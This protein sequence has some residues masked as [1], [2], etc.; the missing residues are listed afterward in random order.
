MRLRSFVFLVSGFCFNSTH[1]A[2][3]LVTTSSFTNDHALT[4]SIAALFPVVA[5]HGI[6]TTSWSAALSK[7]ISHRNVT[8]TRGID[9]DL[10]SGTG[11]TLLPGAIKC[12][13]GSCVIA[14]DSSTHTILSQIDADALL[15]NQFGT[16]AGT[17][18]GFSLSTGSSTALHE[19]T[20]SMIYRTRCFSGSPSRE[21]TLVQDIEAAVVAKVE[22]T[23]KTFNQYFDAVVSAGGTT[24]SELLG[25]YD[26]IARF[27][28]R[29]GTHSATQDQTLNIAASS[30][31]ATVV[32]DPS[33]S[34]DL[35]GTI[36]SGKIS[37]DGIQVA[38]FNS[39]Q[40][41]QISVPLGT[42]TVS[43]SVYNN[44]G[45]LSQPAEG[46]IVV[47]VGP[48]PPIAFALTSL[49]CTP[50]PTDTNTAV[51]CTVMGS[52]LDS[53]N[54]QLAL[55]GVGCDIV[56][57]CAIP[58]S[59]MTKKTATSISFGFIPTVATS[60]TLKGTVRSSDPWL[61]AN[62]T[63]SVNMPSPAI[64]RLDSVQTSPSSP[65]VG[66]VRITANGAGITLSTTMELTGPQC[67]PCVANSKVSQTSSMLVEDVQISNPGIYTIK[68]RDSGQLTVG[69]DIFFAASPT[70]TLV[71][72][73][74]GYNSSI[75]C[76]LDGKSLTAPVTLN[77]QPIGNHT[78]GCNAPTGYTISGIT[79]AAAQTLA[80]NSTVTWT[81]AVKSSTQPL[82]NATCSVS[83]TS[84][85]AGQRVTYTAGWSGGGSPGF[86]WTE[87]ISGTVNPIQ[88]TFNSPGTYHASV[89]IMNNGQQ[90]TGTCPAVIV[91]AAPDFTFTTLASSKSVQA[92]S[93]VGFDCGLSP[94][95]NFTGQVTVF[96]SGLPSNAT[97]LNSS[98]VFNISPTSGAS[99]TLLLQTTGGTPAGIYPIT[100]TAQGSGINHVVNL[101]L[102]VTAPPLAPLSLSAV[103][104][105]PTINLGGGSSLVCNA[106][107]GSGGY[108]YSLNNGSYQA[109]NSTVVLPQD[110]G[111][112]VYRCS[113]RDNSGSTAAASATL[114]VNGVAPVVS[115]ATWDST[116]THGIPF[117]GWISGSGFTPSSV[118]KFFGPGCPSSGCQQPPAGVSVPSLTSIRLVNVNL[119]AG[120]WQYQVQTAYGTATG[121]LT[122]K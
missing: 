77:N 57:G 37:V 115:G 61:A 79:P 106:S 64:V 59:S 56:K 12:V 41:T 89:T 53:P 18:G 50:N 67:S 22:G 4:N 46:V 31:P 21:E 75:G 5:S 14:N 60:L 10:I 70:G 43:V 51:S 109:S 71:V 84:I 116:P 119:A 95:N 100:A 19:L 62:G 112:L 90:I 36:S 85:Q 80:A 108:Q 87:D 65:V 122:V 98:L 82:S 58:T 49:A 34:V 42:H 27:T 97:I 111:S 86:N 74:A 102:N 73:V 2:P 1:A 99:F 101:G 33:T 81:V 113:V 72:T 92:G 68:L 48:T 6:I 9:F 63:L 47:T 103:I 78:L 44:F 25:L 54:I 32:V 93:Q 29:Y 11:L 69:E 23:K 40:A 35:K 107:G 20:H 110:G 3:L 16:P 104:S 76:T 118:A 17:T 8:D 7:S 39:T 114:T 52:G 66:V 120:N 83:A 94:L 117:S 96:I 91:T 38:S 30:T 121:S 105:P 15:A 55:F 88:W 28:M 45:F 24:C 26:P 13:N